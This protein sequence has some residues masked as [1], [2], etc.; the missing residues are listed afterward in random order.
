MYEE[1]G[2]T[3]IW[4]ARLETLTYTLSILKQRYIIK[5]FHTIGFSNWQPIQSQNIEPVAISILRTISEVL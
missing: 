5:S 2:D 1:D 3:Y 4:K